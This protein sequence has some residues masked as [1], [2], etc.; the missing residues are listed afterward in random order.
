MTI[1]DLGKSFIVNKKL[2]L[3]VLRNDRFV[4]ERLAY[5]KNIEGVLT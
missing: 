3:I 5:L 2:P 1:N 4:D